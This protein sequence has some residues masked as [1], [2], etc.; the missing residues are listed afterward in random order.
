[1]DSIYV[2]FLASSAPLSELTEAAN[3]IAPDSQ[4]HLS[5]S[6]PRNLA[7]GK[8]VLFHQFPPKSEPST[9]TR[10]I[11]PQDDSKNRIRIHCKYQVK[12]LPS[13]EWSSVCL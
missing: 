12:H 11:N 4:V 10:K 1:M 2:C 3:K 9:H 13:A 5:L 8:H 7:G 6:Y